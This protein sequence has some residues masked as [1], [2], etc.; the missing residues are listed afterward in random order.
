MTNDELIKDRQLEILTVA[1]EK[2]DAELERCG[3]LIFDQ[4]KKIQRLVEERDSARRDYCHYVAADRS[5]SP[6]NEPYCDKTS[7]VKIA[8]EMAWDCFPELY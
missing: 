4:K 8:V 5:G 2:R 6:N 1:L 7:A 3:Q